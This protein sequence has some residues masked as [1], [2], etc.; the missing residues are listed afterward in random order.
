MYQIL[1]IFLKNRDRELPEG[2]TYRT[3]K[4]EPKYLAG[5]GTGISIKCAKHRE[6]HHEVPG[7][8]EQKKTSLLKLTVAVPGYGR[9]LNLR[10]N[11]V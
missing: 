3:D 4:G 1:G 7:F 10:R 11:S 6:Q 8:A 9:F 2:Q 5:L